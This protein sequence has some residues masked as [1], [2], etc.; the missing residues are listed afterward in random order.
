MSEIHVKITDTGWLLNKDGQSLSIKDNGDGIL[1]NGD[2]LAKSLSGSGFNQQDITDVSN[3]LN[4]V[5]TQDNNGAQAKKGG[6]WKNAGGFMSG[7]FG[8]LGSLF[9]GGMGFGGFGMQDSWSL[10][11]C[12]GIGFN[13]M[14]V[15]MYSR[16]PQL[17]N[18]NISSMLSGMGGMGGFNM[19]SMGM[20]GGGSMGMMG[21]LDMNRLMSIMTSGMQ[22]QQSQWSNTSQ[23]TTNNTATSTAN[24]TDTSTTG[25][26]SSSTATG[27][28]DSTDV[29]SNS[30]ANTAVTADGD[31]DTTAVTSNSDDQ[32]K[33]KTTTTNYAE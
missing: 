31:A 28:T 6:F 15:G 8:G 22:Q 12:G 3:K 26:T 30:V 14:K 7:L 11:R 20:M 13:D 32:K 24:T 17:M 21:G 27:S 5:N 2:E 1:N 18:M 9:M 19:G 25:K 10:N 16:Q 29:T 33:K 4:G 23:Q